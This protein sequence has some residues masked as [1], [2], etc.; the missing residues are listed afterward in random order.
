VKS[1]SLRVFNFRRDIPRCTA[2]SHSYVAVICIDSIVIMEG[3]WRH[4]SR[5]LMEE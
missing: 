2:L 1:N 4:M 5:I 3:R